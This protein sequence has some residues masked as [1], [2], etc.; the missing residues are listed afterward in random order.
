MSMSP[1]SDF[2]DSPGLAGAFGALMDEYA[3]AAAE[4][5]RVVTV[6]SGRAP[7]C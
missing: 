4:L 2:I 7:R 6:G 1:L 3:R 5:C